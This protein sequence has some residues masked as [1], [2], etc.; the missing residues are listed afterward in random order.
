MPKLMLTALAAAAI[1][2]TALSTTNAGGTPYSVYRDRGGYGIRTNG[3]EITGL[4]V[5]RAHAF[6]VHAVTLFSGETVELR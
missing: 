1:G 6:G 2:T 5:A 4:A 3:T